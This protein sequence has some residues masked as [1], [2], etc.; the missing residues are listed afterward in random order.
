MPMYKKHQDQYVLWLETETNVHNEELKKNL[1]NMYNNF[2]V[3][4]EPSTCVNFILSLSEDEGSAFLILDGIHCQYLA[5]M[6]IDLPHI[7]YIYLYY[8]KT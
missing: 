7:A 1:S 3:Y 8:E 6:I 5:E 2:Q 4:G